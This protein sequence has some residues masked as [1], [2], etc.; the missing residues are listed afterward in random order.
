MINRG[1]EK[2]SPAEVDAALMS[3]PDVR[4]AATSPIRH[5]TLG[6]EVAAAVVQ[7]PG[8][9]LTDQILTR[10]LLGR[11]TGFKVPRRFFFVDAIPKSDAGKVQRYRLA[12]QLGIAADEVGGEAASSDSREPTE[13]EAR[14]QAI[15]ARAL[16]LPRVGLD[17][18]FFLLGGDSLQAVEMF[19]EIEEQLG[20]R[21]PRAALFE[22]GT[23][24]EMA[25]LI[26]GGKGSDCLVA[27]QPE[28]VLAPFFCVHD[29]NGDVLNFRDLA[30]HMGQERPFYGIQC[31]GLDG[32]TMPFTRIEDMAAHYVTA[33]RD[34]E[35]EGPYLLGGYSFGGRIAYV[36]AQMLRQQGAEVRLLA[37]L[38]SFS[39]LQRIPLMP[40]RW[41]QRHLAR[42]R[43]TSFQ[44]LPA[45]IGM[46]FQNVAVELRRAILTRLYAWALDAC[47]AFGRKYPAWLH[48]PIEAN[49]LVRRRTS[50]TPYDGDA[51]LF[52]TAES[53]DSFNDGRNGWSQLVRG[54]LEVIPVPGQHY[55]IV[56]QPHVQMLA[57]ELANKIDK[58][59]R[60]EPWAPLQSGPG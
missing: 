44:D 5:P 47:S 14:L 40:G 46:R 59:E 28:G 13:L 31:V 3:H 22:A 15:W 2:V 39:G 27:I 52:Q 30:R 51:V 58:L 48:R 18:N 8:A 35:P 50:L 17:D 26:E 54:H 42:L 12:E 55:Q 11:L 16:R 7:R 4:E 23:V 25:A 57:K 45:Y 38:D 19:L 6:E 10:Y 33:I 24:A 49:D 21:L 53:C 20:R 29:G 43:E 41:F 32:R 34:V 60:E 56:K 37:L 1:G 36:M 9:G